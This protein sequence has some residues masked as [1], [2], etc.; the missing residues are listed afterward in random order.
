[1][2]S[3]VVFRASSF[4]IALLSLAPIF[5]AESPA[6]LE[7]S[8]DAPNE[9]V[10]EATT[11]RR[12]RA[13]IFA[14][15]AQDA[16]CLDELEIYADAEKSENLARR[17]DAKAAASSCI[18]G[19]AIHQIAHL[20]DGR[21]GNAASWIAAPGDAAPFA[22]ID[23]EEPATF[24][25]VVFSR[26]RERRYA[27]RTPTAL[28][29]SV[30]DDGEN[31]RVVWENR[32]TPA[33]VAAPP[34][35]LGDAA[36]RFAAEVPA[37]EPIDWALADR[38]A[39]DPRAPRPVASAYDL[40]LQNAFLY[41]EIAWLKSAG[42]GDVE[43]RLR[44]RNYPEYVE[45][46][47]PE[48]SVLPLPI[49]PDGAAPVFSVGTVDVVAGVDRWA[50]GPLLSQTVAAA[51]VGDELRLKISGNRFLSRNLALVGVAG[52]A[53]RALVVL[54]DDDSLAWRPLDPPG[55]AEIALEG[56]FDRET[57]SAEFAAPLAA[58]PELTKR[59]LAVGL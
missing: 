17:P 2:F 37:G 32:E 29:I 54:R 9:I 26:D 35:E 41:E 12:I 59:G 28:E 42:F 30:S 43:P 58:L 3:R 50:P 33:T 20:N 56:R 21:V 8:P 7:F 22:E 4:L 48:A 38:R 19:F 45:P 57:L 46:T 47:A 13:T 23:W 39:T 10:F 40:Q 34:G 53:T 55:A 5:A 27:D 51:V 14:W 52:T 16:P 24:D 31:W 11:A 15:N 6:P 18:A 49:L 1:M 44:Q 36:A 25:R